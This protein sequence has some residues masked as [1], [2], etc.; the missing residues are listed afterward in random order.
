[1][2]LCPAI[3]SWA[4]SVYLVRSTLPMFMRSEEGA[5]VS[6]TLFVY[7]GTTT[8]TDA[9]W[10]VKLIDVFPNTLEHSGPWASPAQRPT[11]D[12]FLGREVSGHLCGERTGLPENN[13]KSVQISQKSFLCGS[14]GF[15]EVNGSRPLL[16]KHARQHGG[17]DREC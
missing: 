4:P 17:P 13:T 5:F 3:D 7:R 11:A 9:D 8:G 10:I 12:Q 14:Q 2:H 16:F 15:T 1:M 6:R